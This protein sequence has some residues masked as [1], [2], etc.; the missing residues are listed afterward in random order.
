MK[1]IIDTNI[2]ISAFV[3]DKAILNLTSFSLLKGYVCISDEIYAELIDK[4]LKGRVAKISKSFELTRA[5][6][7]IETIK[8]QAHFTQVT[9][10]VTICRD[11]K[12]NKFLELAKTISAEYI[13]SGD[14]DLLD[15]KTFENTIITKPSEFSKLYNF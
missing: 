7:F 13:I 3:F 11:P 8:N 1:V 9:E 2:Y 6:E 12:D 14:K 15:L 5:E 10:T 4:F